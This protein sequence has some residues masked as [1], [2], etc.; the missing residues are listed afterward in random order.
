MS[1]R[2]PAPEISAR[3]PAAPRPEA[4]RVPWA[5]RGEL[6]LN[7]NCT[8]FCP[9]VVSLG[10]HPPTEGRCQ[11]WAGVRIDEGHYGDESLA[12]LNVGLLL[13]IPGLMAR[14]NWTAAAFIDDRASHAAHHGLIEIFSGRARGTTGLFGVLVSDFLGAERAPVRFETEGVARRLTVGKKIQGEVVPVRGADPGRDIMVTN[15]QYW[16]GPDVTVATATRGRVRAF[17]RVWDFDGRSAEI[18]AIDWKGPGR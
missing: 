2:L 15:T 18:C 17:G 16:M 13:E 10:N 6:I 11:A 14:G 9:C 5:I 7:C 12:G 4:G 1:D 3:H 8:V